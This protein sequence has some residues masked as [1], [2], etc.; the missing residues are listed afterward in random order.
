MKLLEDRLKLYPVGFLYLAPTQVPET[1]RTPLD[2]P[3][4]SFC[5][6]FGQTSDWDYLLLG[7][8]P[9]S[10]NFIA[11]MWLLSRSRNSQSMNLSLKTQAWL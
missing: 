4:G 7:M 10:L 1:A 11:V 3:L 6:G 9:Y 2:F 5:R 8:V